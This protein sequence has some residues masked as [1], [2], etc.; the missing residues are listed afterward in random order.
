MFFLK[1][2]IGST[3]RNMYPTG[4]CIDYENPVYV[5]AENT[6]IVESPKQIQVDQFSLIRLFRETVYF[7]VS[8][9]GQSEVPPWG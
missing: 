3:R 6:G 7:D 9:P 8:N 5:W 4:N 2:V 1:V